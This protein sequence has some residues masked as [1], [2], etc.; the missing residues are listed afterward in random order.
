MLNVLVEDQSFQPA[1][2]A[3]ADAW[4]RRLDLVIPVLADSELR[5]AAVWG[6]AQSDFYVQHSYTLVGA[7]GI[8]IWREEENQRAGPVLERIIEQLELLEP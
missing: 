6:N 8:V 4:R 1:D 7:D 3:D 2:V 5:W